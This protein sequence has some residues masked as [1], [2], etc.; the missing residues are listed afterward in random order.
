MT[1]A[2]ISSRM[3]DVNTL[4]SL[5]KAQLQK[6]KFIYKEYFYVVK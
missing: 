2:K 3:S 5:H 1:L 4:P 6:I